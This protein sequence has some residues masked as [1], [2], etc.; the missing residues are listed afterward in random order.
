MPR[1]ARRAR[2]GFLQGNPDALRRA[3]RAWCRY[4]DVLAPLG[5][6]ILIGTLATLAADPVVREYVGNAWQSLCEYLAA[7]R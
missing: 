1:N 5:G 3:W 4:V 7:L 6:L 2:P